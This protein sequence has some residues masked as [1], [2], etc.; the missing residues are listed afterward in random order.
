MSLSIKEFSDDVEAELTNRPQTS[1]C[2]ILLPN[3]PKFRA[4]PAGH[5]SHT[6]AYDR[7]VQEF[8]DD[9]TQSLKERDTLIVVQCG[10]Q[11]SEETMYS[12]ARDLRLDFI[13]VVSAATSAASGTPSLVS[14][15]TK[16]VLYKRRA[17]SKLLEAFPRNAFVNWSQEIST[18]SRGSRIEPEAEL[19]QWHSGQAVISAILSQLF[20]GMNFGEHGRVQVLD[21][22]V[23]DDQIMAAVVAMNVANDKNT[24]ILGYTGVAWGAGGVPGVRAA[25]LKEATMD[26]LTAVARQD[27]PLLHMR[28]VRLPAKPVLSDSQKPMYRQEDYIVTCPVAAGQLAIRQSYYDKWGESNTKTTGGLSWP[29]VV[30]MHNGKFNISGVPYKSKRLADEAVTALETSS[31][32]AIK[33]PAPAIDQPQTLV[34]LQKDK[35]IKVISSHPA[36]YS[37]HVNADGGCWIHG[38]SEGIISKDDCLFQLR[39]QAKAGP[40]AAKTMKDSKGWV[41][42][43]MTGLDMVTMSSATPL[44]Q[45]FPAG[46]RPLNEALNFLEQ[47]GFVR[48]QIHLHTAARDTE[49]PGQHAVKCT[50]D[51]VWDIPTDTHFPDKD[52]TTAQVASFINIPELKNAAML[53]IV[54]KLQFNSST[55]KILSGY[56]GIFFKENV[57]IEKGTLARLF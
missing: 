9:V 29:E 32:P 52:I 43:K 54:P 7:A 39:G 25:N 36:L 44:K 18:A 16:S 47:L 19:R 21:M 34:D 4:V 27:V 46:P 23:Y 30:Q 8:K 49:S 37:L 17:V 2:I 11:Y 6:A 22:T 38:E 41:Q 42:F 28:G 40:A 24:P 35:H 48:V 20:R 56:P 15:W 13:M 57:Q 31:H 53:Q 1:C 5:S 12:H 10:G 3:T 51:G 33:L 55:N 14:Q 50:D 45:E 26:A